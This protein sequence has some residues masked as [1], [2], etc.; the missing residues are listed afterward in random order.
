MKFGILTKGKKTCQNFVLVICPWNGLNINKN[1]QV[2]S[3]T[4]RRDQMFQL[5]MFL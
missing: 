1:N 3:Q 2:Q 5:Q 4:T